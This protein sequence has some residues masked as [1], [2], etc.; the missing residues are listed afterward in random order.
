MKYIFFS[1]LI[2]SLPNLLWAK[3]IDCDNTW[4]HS[5]MTLC[6]KNRLEKEDL[7]LNEYYKKLK[8]TYKS[9]FKDKPK[10]SDGING[11]ESGL[12]LTQR[13][14]I[15]YRDKKCGLTYDI[16][17]P[18]REANFHFF[19]CKA[20]MTQKRADELQRSYEYWSEK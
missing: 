7:R 15:S 1:L 16:A 10:N 9:Y 8:L 18:G 20:N 5:E 2:L 13:A 11:I 14:W 4:K 19:R 3:D 6:A 12:L 17:Y